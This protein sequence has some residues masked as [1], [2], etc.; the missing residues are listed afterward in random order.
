MNRGPGRCLN[1]VGVAL[2]GVSTSCQLYF[3][4]P[5]GSFQSA[6]S[7][8][9]AT[10]LEWSAAVGWAGDE[11]GGGG[12]QGSVRSD[13]HLLVTTAQIPR[14]AVAFAVTPCSGASAGQVMGKCR[15]IANE[16]FEVGGGLYDSFFLLLFCLF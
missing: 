7:Q 1:G 13:L 6:V 15:F 4:P 16:T 2:P 10:A 5:A 14:S 9:F 8:R 11:P 3:P 12:R